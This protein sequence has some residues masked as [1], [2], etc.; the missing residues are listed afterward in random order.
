MEV[1]SMPRVVPER[2]EATVALIMCCCSVGQASNRCWA[3]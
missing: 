1:E 3:R 2:S